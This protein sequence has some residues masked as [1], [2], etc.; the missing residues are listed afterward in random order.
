MCLEAVNSQFVIHGKYNQY[1]GKKA[2]RVREITLVSY[3]HQ[4]ERRQITYCTTASHWKM[5]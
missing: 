2:L 3:K 5:L 1:T 4:L